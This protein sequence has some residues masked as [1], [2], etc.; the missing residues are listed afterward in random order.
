MKEKLFLGSSLMAAISASFCCVVP[1]ASALLGF[2]AVGAS[3]IFEPFRFYLLGF[4]LLALGYSF[5]RVYFCAEKCASGESC[6]AV[7]NS[8][9][10]NRVFLWTAAVAVLAISLSPYYAGNVIA[11]LRKSPEVTAQSGPP[12][13]QT[14]S[15]ANKTVM[16]KIKGMTCEGCAVEINETLRKMQGVV[17]V[18]VSYANKNA[19]VVYDPKQI[20]L[21]EIKRAINELGYK[22]K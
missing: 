12:I 8:G 6:A 4:A 11:A 9:V 22:A 19:Q 18:D 16:I 5:Y 1:L 7:K 14:E 13:S 3:T 10:L 15:D 20:T 21:D 17:S 2:G